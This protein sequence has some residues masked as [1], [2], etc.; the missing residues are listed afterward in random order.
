MTKLWATATPEHLLAGKA[1]PILFRS[2]EWEQV[3]RKHL[4]WVLAAYRIDLVVD[5]GGNVGQFGRLLRQV[6]Y[7]GRIVSFEPVPRYAA[8]L[9]QA[10]ASDPGWDAHRYALGCVDTTVAMN[11]SNGTGSSMLEP[12]GYGTACFADLREW[13]EVE[14]PVRRL[15]TVMRPSPDARVLLKMDTQGFDLEVFAGAAGILD[16][17]VALQSEVSLLPIYVGM[18][19][20]TEAV[21]AYT[22]AGYHI[23][24]MFPVST[25]G[26]TGRVLEFDCLLV[27]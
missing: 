13:T 17:V 11:V 10:A 1:A 20:M 21:V 7:Q 3:Y 6:S 9:E 27:R 5:A 8:E 15:D 26:H 4:A 16:Q 19:T 2:A 12:N 25:E 22:R 14:V 24:G 23:T 18:P